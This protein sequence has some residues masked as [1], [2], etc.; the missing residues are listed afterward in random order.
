[1]KKFFCIL[2]SIMF[3][4]GG[5]PSMAGDYFDVEAISN[6]IVGKLWRGADVPTGEI[7]ELFSL[8]GHKSITKEFSTRD[9]KLIIDEWQ[10]SMTDFLT[11]CHETNSGK[12]TAIKGLAEKAESVRADWSPSVIETSLSII[13]DKY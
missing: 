13:L 12:F 7:S 2:A 4:L 8:V 6:I 11:C 10:K 1:M 9:S 3:F 5:T